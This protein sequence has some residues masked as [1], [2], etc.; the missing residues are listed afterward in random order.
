MPSLACPFCGELVAEGPTPEAAR[1]RL[2]RAALVFGAVAISVG[3]AACSKETIAQ[4]Y[5]APPTPHPPDDGGGAMVALYGGP[6]EVPTPPS[7]TPPAS[8]TAVVAPYG[9]PQH[10]PDAAAPKAPLAPKPK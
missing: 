9:A 4:P 6:P 1:G 7:A 10:F 5:G 8:A 2:S 3:A